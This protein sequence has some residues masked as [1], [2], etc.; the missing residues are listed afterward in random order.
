MGER[1]A[2]AI[3]LA[4]GRGRRLGGVDKPA[5][6]IGDRTLLGIAL[7]A[8][9]GAPAIVVGPERDLPT[10]VRV[11]REDPPGSG[12][13]AAIAAGLAALPVLT[14][15][16]LVVILAA[17]LPAI[18]AATVRHLCAGVGERNGAV[19]VDAG[20]RRQ[21]LAGVW[22]HW[23][24]VDAVR[25]R[26]DWSGRSVRELLGPLEPVELTG[27]EAATADVDTPD[28]WQRLR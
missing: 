11:V 26:T 25:R 21:W 22:R 8:V 17:D 2:A 15:H 14:D 4:G 12:P 19:L 7:A 6:R 9:A 3:V 10:G 16:D 5:L 28:D 23:P 27:H 1:H 13:A 24:L 18:D 20:G